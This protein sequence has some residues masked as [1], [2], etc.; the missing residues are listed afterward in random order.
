[1]AHLITFTSSR[2]DVSAE[3]PNPINAIAGEGVLKW[4]RAKLVAAGYEA[5]SPEPEDWGW[6]IYVN[7]GGMSYLVGASSDVD[8]S[9]PREWIIQ[10]H[11]ERTLIDKLFG[12]NKLAENDSLTTHIEEVI[13]ESE[14]GK[15]VQA[16]RS[17]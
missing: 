4:L 3:R 10:I 6:Y 17:A 5:T 14:G 9:T 11:R 7:G 13:R 16:D 2:F 15:D 8:H 12:K 1:M